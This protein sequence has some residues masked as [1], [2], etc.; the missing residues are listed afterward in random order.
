MK[1]QEA[2]QLIQHKDLSVNKPVMWADLG[3]GS[4][5]FTAALAHY[6]SAGSTIYAVDK[7]LSADLQIPAPAGVQVNPQQL[8]FVK[9]DLPFPSLDGIMMANALHYVKDQPA[10]VHKLKEIL[11]PGGILMIVEYDTD[12]PVP[13]WVPHP[14]SF[15]S[16]KKLFGAAGYPHIEKTGERPSVYGRANMYASLI[17][18]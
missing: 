6:L 5:T 16:L 9:E 4:G 11:H 15:N 8:D 2:I 10:F 12:I 13:V 1:L 18:K 3:C 7:T 17:K 14:L